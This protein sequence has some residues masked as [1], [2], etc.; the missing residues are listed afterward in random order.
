M[1][2][3]ANCL[4]VA[5]VGLAT[6]GVSAPDASAATLTVFVDC[7]A[8]PGG[9]GSQAAPANSV[10][11]GVAIA[12]PFAPTN[13]V[14][15]QVAGTC[16]NE[17]L[18]IV[19]DFSVTVLG[20][21]S[22]QA[23][24]T[25]TPPPE[26]IPPS[27]RM[28]SFFLVT[29]RDVRFS[30]LTIDGRL[31]PG[32]DAPL[33]P[34]R[35]TVFQVNNT[36]GFEA[37][38]LLVRQIG[39]V[40]RLEASS[41]SVHDCLFDHVTRGILLTGGSPTAPPHSV[42]S[43]NLI[44]FRVNGIAVGGAGPLGSAL[45]MEISNNVVTSRY[46]NT[47]PSNPAAIRISP[48]V[49]TAITPGTVN[50]VVANNVVRGGRYGVMIHAGQPTVRTDGLLYTGVITLD[51]RNNLVATPIRSLITFTNARA[52][53]LPC[54]LTAIPPTSPNHC[55]LAFGVPPSTMRWEYLDNASYL[56]THTGELDGG[57]IDH[58]GAQPVTGRILNNVLRINGALIGNQTFLVVPPFP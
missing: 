46:T 51:L 4:L 45:S 41:G 34:P 26:P 12:R 32:P 56:L 8:G 25:W 19:I 29:G 48:L 27:I 2:I 10:T 54:E 52:T 9:N 20:A 53:V 6:V 55:A 37:S 13:L 38:S 1:G 31:D 35:P 15:I 43:N 47:G 5:V 57:L 30:S 40:V 36:S 50:G 42:V 58:P 24:I 17:T 39:E 11:A 16:Q 23:L 44:D 14:T 22:G 18:P 33:D 3:N 28:L 7:N 21:S 49:L